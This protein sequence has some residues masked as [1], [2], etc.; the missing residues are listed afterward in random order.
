MLQHMRPGTLRTYMLNFQF[1]IKSVKVTSP[2]TFTTSERDA[3]QD[4]TELINIISRECKDI[5]RMEQY[6]KSRF[7]NQFAEGVPTYKQLRERVG[8]VKSLRFSFFFYSP[9]ILSFSFC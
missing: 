3:I 8:V 6:K 7:D 2:R 9:F 1:F 4:V 5:A